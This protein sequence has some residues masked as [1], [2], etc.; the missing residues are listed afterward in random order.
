LTCGQ[1]NV[2]SER[3]GHLFDRDGVNV[4][5][6]NVEHRRCP[7]CGDVEVVIPRIE[8]LIRMIA[9]EL[10]RKPAPLVGAEMRFLRK[11]AGWS[12]AD[13]ARML[14]TTK[15]SV[16]RWENGH[17]KIPAMIDHGLRAL[18]ASQKPIEDYAVA[19]ALA[20]IADQQEPAPAQIDVE[21]SGGRWR[22]ASRAA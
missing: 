6:H 15:E 14:G 2:G 10:I 3:G 13:T 8:A 11:A 20:A 16:S 22:S 7:D 5:L 21:D 17:R 4:R 12:A 18:A 9:T 1:T 19:D